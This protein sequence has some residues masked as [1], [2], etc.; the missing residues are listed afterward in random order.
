MTVKVKATLANA[1]V[2]AETL[3]CVTEPAAGTVM[4]PSTPGTTLSNGGPTVGFS[5][6]GDK[7]SELEE[8]STRVDTGMPLGSLEWL[9]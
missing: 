8:V 9:I 2:G 1:A 6:A 5:G 7:G 4:L 3:K